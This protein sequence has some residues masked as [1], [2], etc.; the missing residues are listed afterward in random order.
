MLSAILKLCKLLDEIGGTSITDLGSNSSMPPL[1]A[2]NALIINSLP[3]DKAVFI[4]YRCRPKICSSIFDS[5]AKAINLWANQASLVYTDY[6]NAEKTIKT[7]IV[8]VTYRKYKLIVHHYLEGTTQKLAED[9]SYIKE[10]N[11]KYSTNRS[12]E[13]S[14]EYELVGTPDNASGTITKDTEVIYYYKKSTGLIVDVPKTAAF[15]SRIG[16]V[17]S[18]I[19]IGGSVFVIYDIVHK[20]KM[21]K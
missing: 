19:A 16:L 11:D 9:E 14:A 17:L 10:Y 5:F 2:C 20:K 18:V 4:P 21:N 7:K 3:M 15:M 13:I 6:N 1:S 12:S 8:N